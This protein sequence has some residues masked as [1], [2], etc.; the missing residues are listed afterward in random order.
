MLNW[1]IRGGKSIRGSATVPGDKSIG[2]RALLLA[3][4]AE[5]TSTIQGLS[6]GEDNA[7]TQ[8]ALAQM[9]VRFSGNEE[10]LTVEGVGLHGLKQ[11]QTNI[12][13]GNSGTTMRLLAGIL[14]AQNF[15][16]RMIGDASLSRRPMKRIVE[17]LR[18]RGGHIAGQSGA[19][20][21]EVYPPLAVA[22]L[23]EGE[24]LHGME[25]EMP[26]ASAQVKS[27]LLLSGL[28]ASGPTLVKEPLLSRDHTERML[29]ALGV[30]LETSGTA[31][32]LDPDG[33]SRQLQPFDWH[34]P[35]D[36]SSAA[37][38]IGAALVLPGSSIEL[39]NVGLNPTRT[40]FY[41]VVRHMGAAIDILPRGA[42]C[43]TE[44]V[45]DLHINSLPL[46]GGE[47]GG[48]TIVRMIDEVPALCAVAAIAGGTTRIRDAAELRV[49]ESDRLA[50]MTKLLRA[51]GVQVEELDDGMC[52]TGGCTLVPAEFSS[53]GDHRIAM[54]AALIALGCNGESIV[55][56]VGCVQTSFPGFA[57]LLSELGADIEEEHG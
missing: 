43:G 55:Q 1:R 11:P 10:R 46:R 28:Y 45:S 26:F 51:F 34:A 25:Y 47:A 13:C 57:N 38:L 9:G 37:F 18:A 48:E 19:K 52:I 32:C 5:G 56:D 16:A 49:K 4:L 24:S 44:P 15:G 33:W 21:E 27:S 36:F 40:G 35:G 7:S 30:P 14:V 12:N 3:A 22:P 54:A 53:H 23:V 41:D 50:V 2:H 20:P 42:S 29:I 8:A 17:P 39:V 31:T 6:G